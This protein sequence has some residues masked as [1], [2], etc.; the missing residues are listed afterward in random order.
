ML[1]LRSSSHA[2]TV[3]TA[4]RAASCC[5]NPNT[6]VEMQQNAMDSSPNASAASRQLR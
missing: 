5:G 1:E 4:I 2:C 6:P 3:S